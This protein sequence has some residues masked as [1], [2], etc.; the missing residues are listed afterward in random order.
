RLGGGRH[1][2]STSAGSWRG[3]RLAGR[4]LAAAAFRLVAGNG[5]R[6]GGGGCRG[7]L[8]A[9]GGGHWLGWRGARHAAADEQRDEQQQRGFAHANL[10]PALKSVHRLDHSGVSVAIP[11]PV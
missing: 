5:G 10:L 7:S 2:R 11:R 4:A 8:G 3:R 9:G 1:G 6:R